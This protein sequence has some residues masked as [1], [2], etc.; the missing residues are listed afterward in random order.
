[1]AGTLA[2]AYAEAGQFDKAVETVEKA[3]ALA[4]AAGQTELAANH[5][6]LAE[7]YRSRRP[8]HESGQYTQGALPP[9]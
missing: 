2:A 1:M 6:R 9:N 4:L 3:R 7:L 8:Y 5:K